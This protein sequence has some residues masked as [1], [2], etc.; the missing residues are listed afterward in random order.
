MLGP[1]TAVVESSHASA[2]NAARHAGSSSTTTTVETPR[3]CCNALRSASTFH[4]AVDAEVSSGLRTTASGAVSGRSTCASAISTSPL[5]DSMRPDSTKHF[6]SSRPAQR[7]H[8]GSAGPGRRS[9]GGWQAIANVAC[10]LISMWLH[11]CV[12]VSEKHVHFY[13]TWCCEEHCT[14]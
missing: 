6:A 10:V 7:A 2:E 13:W 11:E 1:P 4:S 5:S 9:S 14:G 8:S 3:V 12:R